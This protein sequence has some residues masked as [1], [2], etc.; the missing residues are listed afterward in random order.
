VVFPPYVEEL[1]FVG[2]LNAKV[3]FTLDER[4][5]FAVSGGLAI[6]HDDGDT[7][8][9]GLLGGVVSFCT[10]A[11]CASIF[12]AFLYTGFSLSD[13]DS[14]VPLGYGVSLVQ[15]LGEHVKLALEVASGGALAS[16]DVEFAEGILV[17]Y[18]SGSSPATSPATSASCGPSPSAMTTST[19]ASSSGSRR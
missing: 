5:H 19:P 1:P 9:A 11:P 4:V 12:S 7:V 15:R 3:A 2:L 16:S 13:D 14:A 17:S 8:S 10:D 18:G 6:A